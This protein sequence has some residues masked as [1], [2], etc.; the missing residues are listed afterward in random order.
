MKSHRGTDGRVS[1]GTK[2]LVGLLSIV[3]TGGAFFLFLLSVR[4]PFGLERTL[5]QRYQLP[6]SVVVISRGNVVPAPPGG[7]VGGNARDRLS[8]QLAAGSLAFVG[9]LVDSI[10]SA[11][12]VRASSGVFDLGVFHML[13]GNLP[14]DGEALALAG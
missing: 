7:H 8:E 2:F 9:P 13:Q 11:P 4:W 6:D 10:D 14:R 5:I 12:Y 3:A 1:V